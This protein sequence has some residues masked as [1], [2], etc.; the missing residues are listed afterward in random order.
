MNMQATLQTT[1]A[2]PRPVTKSTPK[3]NTIFYWII[4]AVFCVQMSFT[5]AFKRWTGSSPR[6]MRN[7][8]VENG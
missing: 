2:A 3:A 4:T 8:K 6:A 5:A 1:I 7:S